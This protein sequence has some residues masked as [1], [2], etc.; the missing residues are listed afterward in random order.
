MDSY[1]AW[2]GDLVPAKPE[3]LHNNPILNENSTGMTL[4]EAYVAFD[5]RESY[6]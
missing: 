6:L 4:D 1:A 2:T 5:M 3:Q